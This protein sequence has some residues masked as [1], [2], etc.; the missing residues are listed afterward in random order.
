MKQRLAIGAFIAA[1][2][3]VVVAVSLFARYRKALPTA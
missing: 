3:L 1:A 2:A